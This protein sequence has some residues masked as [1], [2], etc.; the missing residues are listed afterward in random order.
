MR[1]GAAVL[2]A[3]LTSLVTSQARAQ[4]ATLVPPDAIRL[5]VQ[6]TYGGANQEADYFGA[7]VI[8]GETARDVIIATAEHVVHQGSNGLRVVFAFQPGDTVPAT[9]GQAN[10]ALDLAI[11]VVPRSSIR[12]YRSGLLAFDRRGSLHRLGAGGLVRP[13][14]CP[15]K[16]C[17]QAPAAP[18]R[19]IGTSEREI[20]FES[21]HTTTGN[22]GGGLFNEY[23]ELVGMVTKRSELDTRAI[24]IDEV[25]RRAREWKYPVSLR[26]RA[27][28]RAGYFTTVGVN[29]LT[30]INPKSD[31]FPDSRFPSGRFALVRQTRS[32]L[33]WH[34]SL[35]RLAPD[36]LAVKAGL[37]GAALNLRQGRFTFAPFL[38]AGLGRV[39]GRFDAGGYYVASGSGNRYVPYWNQQ[40][41]DGIGVGGGLDL[42]VLLAPHMIVEVLAGHWSFTVPDSVPKLPTVF[43][44]GGVRWGL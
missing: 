10:Q 26:E 8:I 41:Q 17:W 39:E 6:V 19:V 4:G 23:W 33:T 22:S 35:L 37:V 28:P 25:I 11:L 12:G 31:S 15:D 42:S 38:E 21:Y 3:T 40:K 5:I 7:G 20:I 43:V 18:D 36:N 16:V 27:I 1:P 14:G 24:A 29:F 30:A 32:S 9:V 13:V 34:A 44:G 2:L